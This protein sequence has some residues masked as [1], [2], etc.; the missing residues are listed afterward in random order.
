M[1]ISWKNF[2]IKVS[3]PKIIKNNEVCFC[4]CTKEAVGSH[5]KMWANI[6]AETWSRQVLALEVKENT[7]KRKI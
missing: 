7:N 6:Q 3:A 2:E 5:P 1:C 4:C